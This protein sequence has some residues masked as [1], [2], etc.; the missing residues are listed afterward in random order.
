M[1]TGLILA[2]GLGGRSD[3]PVPLELALYGGGAAVVVSFVALGVLWPRPRLGLQPPAPPAPVGL[4]RLVDAPLTTA[5]LRTLGLLAFVVTVIV[6]A[7]GPASSGVNPAPTWLY[8]WLWVGL[9]PL[10]LL[11]GPVYR[12]LNPLRT[13][14]RGISRLIGDPEELGGAALPKRLG[15]WPAAV[16][17]LVFVWL[18]LVYPAPDSA[19]TVLAFLLGYALVHVAAGVVYGQRWFD[20][21]D[22]FEVYAGLLARLA[23]VGRRPDGRLGLR[24][25]LDGLA[26]LRVDVSLL[27]VI[28][29]LL[30][31]TAFDG[32]TRTPWW[33]ELAS[34]RSTPLYLLIGTLGLLGC[35]CFVAG[36][37]SL[38]AG[39]A[40]T[41]GRRDEAEVQSL[42]AS[43]A[44]SLVP[45]AVGYTVA[46]YFSLLIFQGQAG[47]IL[48]S[49]PL[50][51]GANL[52]GTAQWSI[53]YTA[54]STG[55]IAIVQV[56][57][58]VL[59]HIAGVVIAHDRAVGL[60]RGR[61]KVRAQY[62]L[63]AVMVAYTCGGIALLVGA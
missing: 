23:I 61:A 20:R 25:P 32:V 5:V 38:A 50:A 6:A 29:V 54:V 49:D 53:V 44:P 31:S 1:N 39:A 56:L 36:S 57:A 3:L 13:L 41:L 63:L 21:G 9:V 17:L 4:A 10:S 45:I 42:A 59:G 16:S 46:H 14:S 58:I 40:R 48:A 51:T 47:Y 37:F 19:R 22:G 62:P 34:G 7:L 27:A 24:N 15:A 30:G 18:E 11:F 35:V 12:R 55:V 8:V 60:F 33:E 28:A 26:R 43:F 52:F 2:H